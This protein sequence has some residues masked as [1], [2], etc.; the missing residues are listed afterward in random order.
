MDKNTL[1]KETLEKRKLL[2]PTEL[3]HKSS[4]ITELFFHSEFYHKSKYLMTYID[5]KELIEAIRQGASGKLVEVKD[6]NDLVE[7]YVD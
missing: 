4:Q 5:F 1:R 7:V 3:I 2:S 6:G